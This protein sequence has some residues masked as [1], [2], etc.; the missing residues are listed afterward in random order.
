MRQDNLR[1]QKKQDSLWASKSLGDRLYEFAKP[2]LKELS[3][4]LD[5]RLV[6]TFF[7]LLM[8]ILIQRHR[9]QGLWLSELG[10]QLLGMD[11]APA[12]TKRIAQL[13]HSSK[14]LAELLETWMWE[15]GDQKVEDCL[16]P[17]EA[18]YV[19]WDESEIEKPESLK[20]EGLCAVR[21]VK[22][23]RLK[24]I[25][26]GYFNPPSGRPVFVP[27]FHWFQVIVTGF[28]GTPCL[29]HS[30]WWTT[31]G[32]MASKMRLEEGAVLEHLAKRWEAN[33]I[34]L[35]QRK[36]LALTIWLWLERTGSR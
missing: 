30:H 20:S 17:Q 8:V 33:N 25:K 28:K 24:R 27:G 1:R 21:S 35:N 11:R 31:R 23:R 34:K 2:M 4:S 7:D 12:G 26:P 14:W 3:R 5:R 29:A 6:Q 22:A 9:N 36:L 15:Q 32:E 10:G 18:T 13:L 19:I 16:H